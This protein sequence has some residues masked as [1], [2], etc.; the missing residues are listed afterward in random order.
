MRKFSML[1]SAFLLCGAM[2]FA[3]QKT[4]T[5][6]VTDEKGDPVPFATVKIKGT[7]T[8]VSADANGNFTIATNNPSDVLVISS[9]GF[10]ISE[11]TVGDASVVN[12]SLKSQNQ[13]LQEV[14]V[15]AFGVKRE[16][17]ALGYSAQD[18]KGAELTQANQGNTLSALSGKVAGLQVTNSTGS[19]GGAAYIRLR[20]ITS[21]GGGQPLLV[22]DGVPIDNST[23][24]TSLGNVAQSNRAIDLN[25]DDIES[26]SV[27][28]GPAAASLYGTQGSDGVI[29]ITT[30][31][32]KRKFE[33]S[34]GYGISFDRVNK[35]PEIQDKYV[36]GSGGNIS[37][38]ASGTST[39]YGA[40]ADTLMW[41]GVA[42]EWDPHGNI[43]GKS[44]PT[45]TLKF[46]PYDNAKQFYRTGITQ[47]H[48][49]SITGGNENTTYRFSYSNLD[50]TGIIALSDFQRNTIRL[51]ADSR[52]TDKL[53]TGTS[54]SYIISGGDR[55]QEGS[56]TSGVM[57]GLL[58]TPNSFDNSN[59]ASNADDP[60]SYLL[61][62]SGYQRTYR[63]VGDGS[64]RGYYDNP[65]WTINKSKFKDQV[66][67]ILGNVYITYDFFPWLSVTDRVGLDQYT[68]DRK[69]NF[70][71]T[72][73][74]AKPGSVEY[75]NYFYQALNND[76]LVTLS[77]KLAN[78]LNGSLLLG[79]NFYSQKNTFNQSI[80]NTL[81]I[82]DFYDLGNSASQITSASNSILRKKSYFAQAKFEFKNFLFVDGTIRAENSSAF[83][84][85]ENKKGKWVYFPS[86]NGSFVFSDALH[87]NRKFLTYGKIRASYG[88]AGR[89]PSL[90]STETYY[91]SGAIADGWTSGL[92][93]PINGQQGF[94]AGS[95]GNPG[96]KPE[97]TSTLDL[98]AELKFFNGRF[99]VDFTYY[100]SKSKDLLLFLPLAPSSGFGSQYTNAA[101]IKNN[102]IELTV[103][104]TPLQTKDFSWDITVNWSMNRSK[105][106]SLGP[107]VETL[108]LGGFT[109]G[110]IN[111]VA[112]QPFGMIYGVGYV[113]DPNGNTVI[114]DDPS[115]AFYGYPMVDANSRALGDPNPKWNGGINNRFT[116]KNFTFSVLFDTRQKFDMWDGTRGALVN[117]G[118]AKETENR[119]QDHV[120]EGVLGHLDVNGNLVLGSGKADITVQPNQD[121]YQSGGSGFIVNEPFVED[122][123]WV[124]L[125]EAAL[126]YNVDLSKSVVGKV[127]KGLDVS[128][129]GRNL[130]LF[131]KYKG[132]DPETSL[133]GGTAL[134][135][136]YF[137]N[138]GTRAIGFNVKVN[139]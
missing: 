52:L 1:V 113:K 43:V 50:Q 135:I 133:A 99:G 115:D 27:L 38:F 68:D 124:K 102:G 82:P 84:S 114:N 95:L 106:T 5:G 63:G 64:A 77:H 90:Y 118:T 107:G 12:I 101:S 132:V 87:T 70:A 26:V 40:L 47:N 73:A 98:G 49:V 21:L 4:V 29:L 127:I 100:D 31:R 24:G 89:L 136:D 10:A 58:R 85:E 78:E 53:R 44:N 91:S 22:V 16:K 41:T 92:A 111:A 45:G 54:I 103:T 19:P 130:F 94:F 62:S 57:L 96:I 65:Y 8:G 80:G 75:R 116:Y 121:W 125:R 129:V 30:K 123:S 76:L 93:Y 23:R 81:I 108:F 61:S 59:G 56:N 48:N 42:N 32:G 131:T 69:Q 119:G 88:L 71:I 120:F 134:G 60:K 18:I 7:T 139:F 33:L 28:K 34:Y 109:N 3:Q 104:G 67:R 36:K 20:G 14:V 55:V 13:Q 128:V 112:G 2:L 66:N 25:P 35:L 39:S 122:A 79:N 86:V 105:V 46:V 126:G 6:K 51:N 17:K 83:V 37:S 11:N 117:F 97:I 138:P 74:N 137:N 72:S 110:A 15:T 9:Q